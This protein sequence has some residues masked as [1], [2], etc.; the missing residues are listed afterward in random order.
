MD[1]ESNNDTKHFWV[2]TYAGG[3]GKVY[4]YNIADNQNAIEVSPV[5]HEV[6]ETGVKVVKMAYR[7]V[8]N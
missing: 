8:A 3:K 4:G 6:F 5:S 7:N 1:Y 2:A